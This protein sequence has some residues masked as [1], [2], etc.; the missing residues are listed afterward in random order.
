[1]KNNVL[2]KDKRHEVVSTNQHCGSK[3]EVRPHDLPPKYLGL[4]RVDWRAL[5]TAAAV[6][7]LEI[8]QANPE[9]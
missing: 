2:L 6:K 5:P 8:A 7:R 1:M 9:H 3:T 4:C